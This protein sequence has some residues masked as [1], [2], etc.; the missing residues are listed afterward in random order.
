MYTESRAERGRIGTK[1]LRKVVTRL[2]GNN[3]EEITVQSG[4]TE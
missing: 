1:L 4:W 3:N 2:T